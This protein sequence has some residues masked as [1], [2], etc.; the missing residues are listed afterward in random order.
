MF[1]Y[2]VGICGAAFYNMASREQYSY[3]QPTI[4]EPGKS[5]VKALTLLDA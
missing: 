5:N 1:K 4:S 3:K 2:P